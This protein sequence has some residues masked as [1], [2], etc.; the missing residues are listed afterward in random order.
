MNARQ[1]ACEAVLRNKQYP[2]RE[3]VSRVRLS[4]FV[5]SCFELSMIRD[6]E[7]ESGNLYLG[8]SGRHYVGLTTSHSKL[9]GVLWDS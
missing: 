6:D 5:L 7:T 9:N 1:Q 3:R 8:E 4:S 2:Q